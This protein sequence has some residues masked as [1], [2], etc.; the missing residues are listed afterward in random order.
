MRR[1]RIE[2][3][4]VGKEADA[5]YALCDQALAIDPSNVRALRIL[6]LK[7]LSWRRL[8]VPATLK[9]TSSGPTNWN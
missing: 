3:R 4:I 7:F 9:A 2:G 1:G 6:G 5:A 8:A